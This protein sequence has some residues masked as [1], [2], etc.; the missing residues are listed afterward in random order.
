[1]SRGDSNIQK[2]N[3]FPKFI[4]KAGSLQGQ[5]WVCVA[6]DLETK[7]WVGDWRAILM[8]DQVGSWPG[9]LDV[10]VH[11]VLPL[12]LLGVQGRGLEVGNQI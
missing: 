12:L 1:M 3:V 6:G 8:R 2:T 5:V 7:G 9:C 10:F 11:V 4:A